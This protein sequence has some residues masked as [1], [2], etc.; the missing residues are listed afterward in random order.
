MP[1]ANLHAR[2]LYCVMFNEHFSRRGD[3][4]SAL[5]H[6]FRIINYLKR[7]RNEM[8]SL[9]GS[10]HAFTSATS[11][12]CWKCFLPSTS[13]SSNSEHNKNATWM[14]S[15]VFYVDF[16]SQLLDVAYCLGDVEAWVN[17]EWREKNTRR[18]HDKGDEGREKKL[19]HRAICYNFNRFFSPTNN[20]L[21]SWQL[22]C[23]NRMRK[24]SL[25][26]ALS[27]QHA[28]FFHFDYKDHHHK[29]FAYIQCTRISIIARHPRLTSSYSAEA[30]CL[31]IH[32]YSFATYCGCGEGIKW[33]GLDSGSEY[34]FFLMLM[35]LSPYTRGVLGWDFSLLSSRHLGNVAKLTFDLFHFFLS[36]AEWVG[37]AGSA[38]EALR[39]LIIF[40][41]KAKPRC[42]S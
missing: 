40:P 9:A 18:E 38:W 26:Q 16:W 6:T 14:A 19:R 30:I 15:S 32:H 39:F 42:V 12:A 36:S 2:L 3:L 28:M 27:S 5:V 11:R 24:K 29:P 17:K 34:N 1:K 21:Q 41:L 13:K 8:C 10:I 33:M 22:N 20:I 7:D 23:E 31:I 4:S 25:S 35:I 37:M